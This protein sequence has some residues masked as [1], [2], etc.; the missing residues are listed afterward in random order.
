MVGATLNF[1]KQKSILA[2]IGHGYE[3]IFMLV[4]LPIIIFER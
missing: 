4:L 2:A 3:A 1:F